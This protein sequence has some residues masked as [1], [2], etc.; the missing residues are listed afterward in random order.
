MDNLNSVFRRLKSDSEDRFDHFDTESMASIATISEDAYLEKPT[1]LESGEEVICLFIDLD[2]SS[3]LSQE[4]NKEI[5]AKIYD[6][7][8]Q[9]V[10]EVLNL[11]G[12]EADYIDIKGDGLFGI[13]EGE[14]AVFKAFV[15]AVTFKTFFEKHIKNKFKNS[16]VVL[17]CKMS[18]NIGK[19]L[20]KK[21]GGRGGD[22]NEVWA[23]ELVNNA[24]K[25][26]S[27]NEKIQ[28]SVKE[29]IL[30]DSVLV[31]PEA[32]HELLREK[33]D[34][35][36]LSCGHGGDGEIGKRINLWGEFVDQS[37]NA[38]YADRVYYLYSNWCDWC[39]DEY[40]DEILS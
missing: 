31:V 28:E 9:N 10:Y 2:N 20:V 6:Y 33:E 34:F 12:I 26:A 23:G 32:V 3:R 35:I 17:R 37:K 38:Q 19:T 40:K 13:Y 4:K 5:V 21:I 11:Q 25:I 14:N 29:S 8:T 24:F 30:I 16:N 1:W 22:Y 39:G 36:I 7:F 27:L 18:I 15:A